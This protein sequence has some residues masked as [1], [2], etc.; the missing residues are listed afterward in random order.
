MKTS[1][2]LLTFA[3][4]LS[5]STIALAAASADEAQRLTA[6]FQ[7]Y[8]GDEPG[9]VTVAPAGDSYTAT[10]DLA[11]YIA[12]VKEPGASASVTPIVLSLT[13][14]GGGKWKVDQDQPLSFALK[15]DGKI[16]MKISLGS[17]KGTG[18]FD[19]ALGAMESSVTDYS[20]LAVDQV[21]TDRATTSKVA[22]TIAAMHYET[23]MSGS[24]DDASGTMKSTYTELRETISMPAAP[25]GSMPPMDISVTSPSGS[26][27]AA[28]K[29]LKPKAMMA[30]AAWLVAHPSEAAIKTGQAELKDKLRAA[31]PLF[32]NISGTSTLNELGVNTMLGQFGIQKVDLVIDANGIVESGALREKIAVTGFKAPDGIIP[33][34][35][36][37]LVPQNFTVD[38]NVAGFNLAAPAKLIIDNLDLNKEPPLPK[39]MEQQLLQALLPNGTVTVGL[40]PSEIIASI[41]D[42]KAE[43]SMVAGPAA[44]PS[45][46]ATVKLKGLDAIMAALQAAPPEMGMQQMAPM[47][48]IAKGMAKADGDYLS[49]KIES[50]PTGS[51]TVNGVDPMKMGGQ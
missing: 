6:L 8:L 20:Q 48:I 30:I 28:I 42:L 51:V 31:L 7:S 5:S 2:A 49:W 22:Y 3:L 25:D 17:I 34:W 41:F 39:E 16:D 15:V 10:L 1:A 19:E 44:M 27:D 43:G 47:V 4:L 46:Q 12:K 29:G 38:F 32:A 9:V 26:S 23:A 36:V 21:V 45:G 24:A 13:D 37:S 40:G 35:A 14:Q 50:T 11:P 33:P 18:I